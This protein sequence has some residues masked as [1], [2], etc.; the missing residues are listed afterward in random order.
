MDS[1]VDRAREIAERVH[2]GQVDKL[3]VPYSE[4]VKSVAEAVSTWRPMSEAPRGVVVLCINAAGTAFTAIKTPGDWC[5][6]SGQWRDPI[7]WMP[8]PPMVTT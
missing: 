8:I 5:D 2:S 3:G 7:A 6:S 4:H 1:V